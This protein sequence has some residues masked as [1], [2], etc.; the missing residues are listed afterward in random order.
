MNIYQENSNLLYFLKYLLFNFC[1]RISVVKS[2]VL[3]NDEK[4]SKMLSRYFS[5]TN[6]D[7][8]TKYII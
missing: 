7:A 5:N 1:R 8:N 4:I 3:R 2:N 6:F